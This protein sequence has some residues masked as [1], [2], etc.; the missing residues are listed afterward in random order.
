MHKEKGLEGP[1]TDSV[2]CCF[3]PLVK[4]HWLGTCDTGQTEKPFSQAGQLLL[5]LRT[6]CS[7]Q[8]PSTSGSSQPPE[9]QPQGT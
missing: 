1:A 2:V 8:H 5:L 4:Q 3:G 7:S 9:L 6:Q